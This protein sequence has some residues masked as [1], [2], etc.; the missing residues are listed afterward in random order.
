MS[1]VKL[2]LVEDKMWF[3]PGASLQGQVAWSFDS[4][5][6]RLELR[7]F[8]YTEGRGTQDI[9][10]IDSK[11]LEEPGLNGSMELTFRIPEGPYSFSGKLITLKWAIE[12]ISEPENLVERIE[13][14]I[15]PRPVEINPGDGF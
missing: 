1:W 2:N 14:L 10:I 9:S 6:D 11:V 12:A 13:L 7:L 8:W 5:P 4:E 3:E 15:G